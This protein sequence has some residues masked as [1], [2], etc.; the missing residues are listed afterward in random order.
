MRVGWIWGLYETQLPFP[1]HCTKE[2]YH[3]YTDGKEFGNARLLWI[4]GCVQEQRNHFK[5][6]IY[7]FFFF[8]YSKIK[9]KSVF[10]CF[11]LNEL[12]PPPPV[13][14]RASIDDVSNLEAAWSRSHNGFDGRFQGPVMESV[15]W[16]GPQRSVQG[17]YYCTVDWHHN[18]PAVLW[19]CSGNLLYENCTRDNREPGK[20]TFISPPG[21]RRYKGNDE[22]DS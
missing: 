7:T 15:A 14:Q 13:A 22:L 5:D 4:T 2:R 9:N 16:L 12:Q 19:L 3:I 8:F 11:V 20:Q 17:T 21:V 10:F 18:H 1:V 6:R